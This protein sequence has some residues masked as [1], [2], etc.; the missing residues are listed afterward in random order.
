MAQQNV[1]ALQ[2]VS[3][4]PNVPGQSGPAKCPASVKVQE[5]PPP[6]EPHPSA[7]FVGV[8]SFRPGLPGAASHF[9]AATCPGKN[10]GNTEADNA[11]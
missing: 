6:L 2:N 7:N 3:T 10:T 1:S 5:L 8:A 9:A 11:P 4:R